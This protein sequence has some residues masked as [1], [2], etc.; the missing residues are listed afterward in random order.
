MSENPR[1][2]FAHA[3]RCD[4]VERATICGKVRYTSGQRETQPVAVYSRN[5]RD[6]CA[7]GK[8]KRRPRG[9]ATRLSDFGGNEAHGMNW[10]EQAVL[11]T[12]GTGSFGRT[13]C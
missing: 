5:V 4:D 7:H 8:R 3:N 10:S 6:G 11:V 9:F 1:P 13:A 2:I 12:G